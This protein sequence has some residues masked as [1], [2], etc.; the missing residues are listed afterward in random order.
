MERIQQYI[1]IEQEPKPTRKGVPPAYRPAS[2][3]IVVENLNSRYARDG[4]R[5][6][7][8]VNFTLKSGERVGVGASLT[9]NCRCP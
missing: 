9:A 4:P 5:V 2:G 8:D 7:K 3:D 6:L 1:D